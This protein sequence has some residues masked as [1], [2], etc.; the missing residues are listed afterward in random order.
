VAFAGREQ[1]LLP[2]RN[3][4]LQLFDPFPARVECLRT[5]S[6]RDGDDHARLADADVTDT[7]EQ[8]HLPDGPAG[9]EI[10]GDL[11]E[12]VDRDLVPRFVREAGHDVAVG[13]GIA[14]RAAE[15]SPMNA[16]A[17]S[18]DSG[19]AATRTSVWSSDTTPIVARGR[20]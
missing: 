3:V 13:V 4:V 9:A 16:S 20:S 19:S 11:M 18:T 2:D 12:P 7:V 1:L 17:S 15:G 10:V 8:G 6:G 14:D 5:M